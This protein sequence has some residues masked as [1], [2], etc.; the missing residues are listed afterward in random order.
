MNTE[1]INKITKKYLDL[2]HI[3][4]FKVGD[5]VSVETIIR[6][7]DKQRI[8]VF[9]GLVIAIQ[10]HGTGKT[11]TVRKISYGVGVEKIFPYSSPNV[12]SVKVERY[13]KPRRSKLYYLRDRVGK[14]ALKVSAGE[15]P[16]NQPKVKAAKKTV[17]VEEK[18][19]EVEE[20]TEET[21]A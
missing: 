8:Q 15:A 11:F 10:G 21:K 3:E 4:S 16:K 13:G 14:K 9:K 17:E 18:V 12:A 1:L 6:D 7:G 20:T 19:A 2:S 5:S